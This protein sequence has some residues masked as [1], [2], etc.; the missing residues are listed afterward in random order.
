MEIETC[1]SRGVCSHRPLLRLRTVLRLALGVVLWV[2]TAERVMAADLQRE[3]EAASQAV[4]G[5]QEKLEQEINEGNLAQANQRLLAVF[6][7]EKR[8][9]AQ[10]LVLANML[11]GVD[12]K[13][14]YAMHK[15]VA[16]E[17]PNEPLAQLEWAM[18]QH[19]AGEHAGALAAYEIYSKANPDFAPVHGLAADC[20]IHLGRTREAVS[21]WQ[22]SEQARS[23]SLERL[24]SIVCDVN[25]DPGQEQRRARLC[26]KASTDVD[27]AVELIALDLDFERDW[28]N[29]GPHRGHLAHDLGLLKKLPANP[30]LKAAQCAAECL[31]KEEPSAGVIREVLQ[32][33]GF[34]IDPSQT[35]PAD[36]AL[37][38]AMLNAS[39][40]A[41]VFTREE[42]RR[43]FG[44]RLRELA[45]GSKDASLHNVVAYLYRGTD[46]MPA[47]EQ[48]AWDATHDARFAAGYLAEQAGRKALRPGDPLL[49]RALREFPENSFVLRIAVSV[50]D[51]PDEKLLVQAIK[52]EYRHFSVAGFISRPGARVLRGYFEVLGKTLK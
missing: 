3:L 23:G 44:D 5:V 37:L 11:Y 21:R 19:R 12:A 33:H 40:N 15:Q 25:K 36:G 49:E 48:E 16:E 24:E 47:I 26:A 6:P 31:L 7:K 50:N 45:K 4:L 22:Q 17:L 29:R 41:E 35:L 20:L 46:T 28:W 34:L 2:A 51:P 14:S 1:F 43:R 18:E 8:T 13:L 38:S 32:R 52:A 10:T 9:P 42:A 39:I 30:R 27:A